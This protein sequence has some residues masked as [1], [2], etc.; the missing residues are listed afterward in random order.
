MVWLNLKHIIHMKN[1]K[2]ICLG[3]LILVLAIIGIAASGGITTN[4]QTGASQYVLLGI[5][6]VLLVSGVYCLWQSRL[7]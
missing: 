6:A 1:E 5:S 2:K 7:S 3:P 4:P